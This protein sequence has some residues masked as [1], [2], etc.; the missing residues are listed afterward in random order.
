MKNKKVLIFADYFLPGYKAGGPIKSIQSICETTGAFAEL[1]VVTRNKDLG[2]DVSFDCIRPNEWVNHQ[3]LPVKVMYLEEQKI[4][5]NTIKRIIKSVDPKVIHLNSLL[6]VKFTFLILIAVKLSAKQHIR[7]LLSPRGELSDGALAL[8]PIR[9]K[10]YICFLKIFGLVRNVIWIASSKH[11]KDDI[12]RSF[13]GRSVIKRIDNLPCVGGWRNML[14][15]ERTK[16]QGLVNLVF[17]SRV[18]PMKNLLFALE[19][20]KNVE[21]K[22]EFDIY[23]PLEDKDYFTLCKSVVDSFSNDIKVNF[24]GPLHP[25]QT[26]EVIKEYDLFILPTK[27]ENFGQ[28]IWES[29]ASSVPVLISDRTPWQELMPAGVG[30]DIPL[31]REDEYK[32]VIQSVCNMNE[33]EHAQLRSDSRKYAL[34]FVLNSSAKKKLSELY[35]GG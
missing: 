26:Y 29:L 12:A 31:H 27:G 3:E 28:A 35:L 30:W 24:R 22:V 11:E 5:L 14:K 20:L 8:K 9:K 2:E 33:I 19:V 32:N 25:S 6:S 13:G 34:D 18:A 7:L 16:N 21:C 15:R 17:Y 1:Y 4:G 10:I 23:G